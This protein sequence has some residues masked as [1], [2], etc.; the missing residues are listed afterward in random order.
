MY[1]TSKKIFY[2]VLMSFLN[3]TYAQKED[4]NWIMGYA[5]AVKSP[6]DT[7]IFRL[8]GNSTL[9]FNNIE[10]DTLRFLNGLDFS[11]TNASIS[12]ENGDLLFYTNGVKVY[13]KMDLLMENGDTLNPSR[14]LFER[15]P[16]MLKNGYRAPQ[17]AIIIEQPDNDSLYYIL[18]TTLE[19]SD[20]LTIDVFCKGLYYTK[21]NIK[22]NNGLGKVI[23]K[24]IPILEDTISFNIAVTKHANGKYWWLIMQELFTN[25]NY[26]ILI[27]AD[28]IKIEKEKQSFNSSFVGQFGYAP[29]GK[30]FVKLS[31]DRGLDIYD[32]NRC[33]GKLSNEINI[34]LPDIKDSLH[35]AWGVCIS[36]NSRFLYV[37]F[38]GKVWQFDLEATNIE[39]SKVEICY[40]DGYGGDEETLKYFPKLPTAFSTPQ[41]GPDGKIYIGT[42]NSSRVL[43]V[44]NEPD[45]KGKECNLVQHGL[46]LP[47]LCLGVPNFPNYRLGAMN[48]NSAI[49]KIN[50]H[51]QIKTLPNPVTSYLFIEYGNIDWS[52]D[53]HYTLQI[54]NALGQT[55]LH[56]EL[57]MYSAYQEINTANYPSGIY[58]VSIKGN[59]GVVWNGKVVK[60]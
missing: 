56:K 26:T 47:T 48:C 60:E 13:N 15:E 49:E 10:P 28:G 44:I 32:F 14:I 54:N 51:I 18:H 22:E 6:L 7:G 43:H 39:S 55:I 42:G 3:M 46:R 30:K 25:C 1:F 19:Q 59:Y 40:W 38:T 29:N 9:Y 11:R 31:W 45:K 8:F 23:A 20:D 37:T 17:S 21:I 34:P 50:E 57:P 33:N 36:P 35:L 58:H 12:D 27:H 5:S 2:F 52:G 16:D 24:N 41:L 53:L 4:F